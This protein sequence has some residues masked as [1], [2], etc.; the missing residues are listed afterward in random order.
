MSVN[1]CIFLCIYSLQPI[2][3]RKVNHQDVPL[4]TDAPVKFWHRTRIDYMEQKPSCTIVISFKYFWTTWLSYSIFNS[5]R[6][7]SANWVSC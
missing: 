6:V 5:L 4:N 2:M 3:I 7:I 1:K